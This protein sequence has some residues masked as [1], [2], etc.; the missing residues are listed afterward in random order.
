MPRV[1]GLAYKSK[2]FFQELKI[3]TR[4]DRGFVES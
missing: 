4:K 2:R 3:L 1:R